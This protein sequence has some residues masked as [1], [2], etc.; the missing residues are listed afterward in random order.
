MVRAEPGRHTASPQAD[1]PLPLSAV[2]PKPS[3]ATQ[4]RTRQAQATAPAR[5]RRPGPRGAASI[6]RARDAASLCPATPGLLPLDGP[7]CSV[8]LRQ[9]RDSFASSSPRVGSGRKNPPTSQAPSWQT[10]RPTR[11]TG[12][13]AARLPS[14]S[15]SHHSRR[16][17]SRPRWC[18]RRRPPPGLATRPRPRQEQRR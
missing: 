1:T 7:L 18:P 5:P 9:G 14:P 10:S 4:R 11:L 15:C 3:E 17:E 8:W 13:A 6:K 12:S 2:T 16:S